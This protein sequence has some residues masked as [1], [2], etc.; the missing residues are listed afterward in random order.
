[1]HA[2]VHLDYMYNSSS[3]NNNNTTYLPSY[4]A[5]YLPGWLAG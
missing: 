2:C 4:L 3:N 5:T 1:M